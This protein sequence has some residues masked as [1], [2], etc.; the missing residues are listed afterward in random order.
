LIDWGISRHDGELEEEVLQWHGY[1]I[2]DM[3]VDQAL[4]LRKSGD[5]E[6]KHTF[7]KLGEKADKEFT[8]SLNFW[9]KFL[10][11]V[12]IFLRTFCHRRIYKLFN[13]IILR[14]A[15]FLGV[16]AFGK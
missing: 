5:K 12:I 11:H 4:T 14:P 2:I 7:W 1:A 15:K 8:G 10:A 13:R 6:V 3:N 16:F 9:P